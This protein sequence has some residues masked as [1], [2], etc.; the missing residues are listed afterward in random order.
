MPTRTTPDAVAERATG[1]AHGRELAA[2]R[3]P[4]DRLDVYADELGDPARGEERLAHVD[5]PIRPRL[6][7]RGGRLA[8]R[9]RLELVRVRDDVE[10]PE[11]VELEQFRPAQ[12]KVGSVLTLALPTWPGNLRSL[13]RLGDGRGS[14][15][16]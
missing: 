13:N 3:P 10:H 1:Q 15:A 2:P 9:D 14:R 5:S 8:R 7:D 12:S 6:V 4:E 16:G 11:R